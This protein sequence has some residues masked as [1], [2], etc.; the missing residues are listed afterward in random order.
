MVN[1]C[2]CEFNTT[3]TG[4]ESGG[5]GSL[6]GWGGGGIFGI[7]KCG[8]GEGLVLVA[9]VAVVAAIVDNV[10]VDWE[11]PNHKSGFVFRIIRIMTVG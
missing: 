4:N 11:I 3:A 10:A 9:V 8:C 7:V 2:R 6:W 5:V 1:R